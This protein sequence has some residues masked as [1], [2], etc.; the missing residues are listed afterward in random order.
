MLNLPFESLVYV[1]LDNFTFFKSS[2]E[3]INLYCNL[4]V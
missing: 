2:K 1:T 3:S 4:G